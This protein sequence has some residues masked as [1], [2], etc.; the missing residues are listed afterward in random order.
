MALFIAFHI[1]SSSKI[2][3]I[4]TSSQSNTVANNL[5]W[6]SLSTTYTLTDASYRNVSNWS[7][8]MWVPRLP[9]LFFRSAPCYY[10]RIVY[11]E[12]RWNWTLSF[13]DFE[14]LFLPSLR[15]KYYLRLVVPYFK[16]QIPNH[17][18]TIRTNSLASTL[19]PS[20]VF[21]NY[22]R[23]VVYILYYGCRPGGF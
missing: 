17:Y 9:L 7:T 8:H 6:R 18:L 10:F 13:F 3:E 22:N 16:P 2:S 12:F 4:S 23:Y 20:C 14:D 15:N 11:W 1:S 5:L 21:R 19:Y